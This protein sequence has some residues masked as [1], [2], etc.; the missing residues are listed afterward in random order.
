MVKRTHGRNKSLVW[1]LRGWVPQ[2]GGFL[3]RGRT[4][5]GCT[6]G[7]DP[8]R[9][10]VGSTNVVSKRVMSSKAA[11]PHARHIAGY[12][13]SAPPFLLSRDETP[14]LQPRPKLSPPQ[15]KIPHPPLLI[16]IINDN[17]VDHHTQQLITPLT[18]TS[19]HSLEQDRIHEE[20]TI[21]PPQLGWDPGDTSDVVAVAAAG[22]YFCW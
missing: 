10:A 12:P 11:A 16:V 18:R 20:A 4:D 17:N 14:G 1:I 5:R 15:K 2:H 21:L 6:L 8:T 13:P 9:T 19:A 22:P 7:G 3:D